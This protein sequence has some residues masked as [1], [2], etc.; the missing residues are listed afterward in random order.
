MGNMGKENSMKPLKKWGTSVVT[1]GLALALSGCF[2]VADDGTVARPLMGSLTV[3]WTLDG[4]QSG[5]DCADFGVDRLEIVIYDAAGDEVGELEPYCESFAISLDLEEGRYFADV[6]LV[7]SLDRSA[8][9]TE[10]IDRIDI[11]AETE[12]NVEVDFP[13]DS[14]L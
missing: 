11:I 5:F 8:T 9:L 7:D 13:L 14:F 6:T 10:T 2:F 4:Q 1:L 12:L 3:E